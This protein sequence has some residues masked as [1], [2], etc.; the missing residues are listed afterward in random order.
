V[1]TVKPSLTF[2]WFDTFALEQI[3]SRYSRYPAH[4]ISYATVRDYAD[5]FDVLNPLAVAQGD[6]KDV[7]RPWALKTI[8]ATVR[9]GARVVEIGG[10]QPYVADLLARLGYD[11]WLVDP[12][13]GSGNGPIEYEAYRRACPRVHFVRARF[14]D[15][16]EHLRE[17]SVACAFSISV[18]E[19]LN[20]GELRGIL[21]GMARFLEPAGVSVHAIDH[22]HKGRG[23]ADHLERLRF[24]VQ[25]LGFPLPMLDDVLAQLDEDTETYYLS[26]ESHN[27]WRAGQPYDDFPMRVCVSIQ[28]VSAAGALITEERE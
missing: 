19:H 6:L 2:E 12:Y 22:V 4:G 7:Q 17:A 1:D 24:I 18:L 9:R 11:V 16:L 21:R 10:G 15:A 5:S 14:D 27:R 23:D 13:D 8:L 25:R 20:T 26:A 3:A 28:T